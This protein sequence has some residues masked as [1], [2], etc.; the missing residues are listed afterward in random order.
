MLN[1]QD[2]FSTSVF[3]CN[4]KHI[5]SIFLPLDSISN[6]VP[7]KMFLL[8]RIK[9]SNHKIGQIDPKVRECAMHTVHPI[10]GRSIDQDSLPIATK[11]EGFNHDNRPRCREISVELAKL[12][13]LVNLS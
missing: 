1:T 4:Q 9:G 8:C 5:L 7:G 2:E 3:I 6:A 13:N 10:S 11:G 12:T